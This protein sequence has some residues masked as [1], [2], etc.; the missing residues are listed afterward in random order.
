MKIYVSQKIH[1]H[2]PGGSTAVVIR[3]LSLEVIKSGGRGE[4]GG[5]GGGEGHQG[6]GSH[7][8]LFL[9]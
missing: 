2:E 6:K 4:G 5:G 8:V 9:F 7:Y 1:P 3:E